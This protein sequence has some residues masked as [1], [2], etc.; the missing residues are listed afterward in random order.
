MQL[1][2]GSH[3]GLAPLLCPSPRLEAAGEALLRHSAA[4]RCAGRCLTGGELREELLWLRASLASTLQKVGG[5][6]L[7]AWRAGLP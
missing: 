1:P 3:S 2:P 5:A 4:L 7:A 6:C